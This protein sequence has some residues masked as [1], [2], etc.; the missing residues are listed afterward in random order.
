MKKQIEVFDYRTQD[1]DLWGVWAYGHVDKSEFLAK[2]NNEV[3][4]EEPAQIEDVIHTYLADRPTHE[5][6]EHPTY[7]AK[8][9]DDDA[10]AVTAVKML[11]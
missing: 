4:D 9:Q 3:L 11:N 6:D 1:G 5:G 7:W 8:K 10:V 2:A